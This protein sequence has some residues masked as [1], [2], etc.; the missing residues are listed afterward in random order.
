ML[1]DPAL[2]EDRRQAAVETIVRNAQSQ[3][4][5]IS[6]ILEVQRIM[7]GKLRLD[8]RAVDMG[9]IVRTAAETVQPSA[10]LKNIKLQLL[11]DLNVTQIW[12][13]PDRLQQV[14]WNLLSNAIKFTPAGGRVRVQLQ[15]TEQDCE[16]VVEDNG[17]GIAE[18]FLPY[19]FDRFR[20]ADS[21][22]T[23]RHKG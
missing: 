3:E 9:D 1:R 2:P 16:M 22:S 10:D 6:D 20:Q 23:R 5:L 15:Q 19:V 8:M 13:D 17:P 4:Q 21:S 7:A 18:E 11:L 12:G 14:I